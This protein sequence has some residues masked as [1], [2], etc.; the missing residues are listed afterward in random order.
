VLGSW[1]HLPSLLTGLLPALFLTPL[2]ARFGWRHGWRAEPRSDRF[3]RRRVATTGGVTLALVLLPLLVGRG[4]GMPLAGLLFLSFLVGLWDDRR[5]LSPGVKALLTGLLALGT[6]W[7]GPARGAEGL[8]APMLF[9]VLLHALNIVDNMDGVALGVAVMSLASA[10][11][12][13]GETRL[14]MAAGAALGV[15]LWNLPPARV[16]LGDSGSFLLGALAWWA[17]WRIWVQPSGKL[18]A[19]LLWG[20]PL[21]DLLFVSARRLRRR[22]PPWRGGTDHLAHAL[23]ARWGIRGALAGCLL[24]HAVFLFLS[25]RAWLTM[26]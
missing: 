18:P 5:E 12:L 10:A 15:W 19:L 6:L 1:T 26:P 2:L 24:V 21:L 9:W 22:I 3:G 14:T 23:A 7:L 8:V 17:S 13:L 4:V 11:W 25:W 20:F 16:Y